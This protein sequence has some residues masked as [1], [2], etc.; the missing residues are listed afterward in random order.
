MTGRVGSAPSP[1]LEASSLGGFWD[2]PSMPPNPVQYQALCQKYDWTWK[3][4]GLGAVTRLR[5]TV[6][7]VSLPVSCGSSTEPQTSGRAR[8][9]NWEPAASLSRTGALSGFSGRDVGASQMPTRPEPR[10]GT[11]KRPLQRC[12]EAQ[13]LWHLGGLEPERL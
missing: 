10:N 4:T 11:R 2:F 7:E 3:T 9:Q 1:S 6:A 5:L 8:P 13:R 12:A